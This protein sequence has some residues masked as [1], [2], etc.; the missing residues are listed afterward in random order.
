MQVW[1]DKFK[2]EAD[3]ALEA[4]A[5]EITTLRTG[6]A[7]TALVEHIAVEAYDTTMPLKQLASIT[8]P[9]ARTIFIQPWDR[10]VAPSIVKALERSSLGMQPIA[11]EEGV[12][13]VLPMLTDERRKELLKVVNVAAEEARVKVRRAR[14]EAWSGIQRAEEG[15]TITEDDKFMFKDKLQKEVDAKN[16]AIETARKKKEESLWS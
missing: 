11:S 13:L 4:L 10:S 9:D 6:R 12:R 2:K 1:L 5:R 14:D 16:I 15:G 3:H 8:I 7:T